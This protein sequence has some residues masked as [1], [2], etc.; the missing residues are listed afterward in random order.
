MSRD[1]EAPVTEHIYELA[2]RLR[3]IL[4]VLFALTFII[5][6][7]PVNI[8]GLDAEI[9]TDP[10]NGLKDYLNRTFVSVV[11]QRMISDVL[12]GEAKLIA[13]SWLDT[14]SV[15]FT[16]SFALAFI[17]A[18][19]VV[20]YETYK[21]INPALYPHERKFAFYF[22]VSFT[23]LFSLGVIYAYYLLLPPTIKVLY[24]FTLAAGAAPLFSIKD[25]FYFVALVI[26][27]SGLFFTIPIVIALAVKYDVISVETLTKNRR[28]IIFAVLVFAAVITPDPTPISMTLIALPF[29]LLFEA[30]IRIGS[31]MRPKSTP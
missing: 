25:F 13:Y 11:I 4:I 10:L 14:I 16:V 26:V 5:A 7:I 2:V 27:S 28:G 3:V 21:Y 31:R 22:I 19:P 30:A 1:K 29:I 12:P 17:V 20:A 23:G 6:L 15:Y 8:Q 18:L 24:Y 9:L